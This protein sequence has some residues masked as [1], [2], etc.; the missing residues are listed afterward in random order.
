MK[1]EYVIDG[2][3]TTTLEAFYQEIGQ[4]L[5]GGKA[6]DENLDALPLVLRGDYGQLPETFRLVWQ[7]ASYAQSALGYNETVR[8]LLQRL[9]DCPPTVLIKTA[10]ALR[11]ALRGQGPTVYDWLVEIIQSQPNVELVLNE[12]D[13]L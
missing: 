7:E 5:L 11:A 9:R 4:V 12:L 6:W 1:P 2:R 8:Q 3:R 10:W 13:E